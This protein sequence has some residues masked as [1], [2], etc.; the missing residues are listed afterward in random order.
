MRED[1]PVADP[2]LDVVERLFAAFDRRDADAMTAVMDP[3]VRFE[4]ASL[5]IVAREPYVGHAGI[6]RYL[7]DLADTWTEFRVRIGRL[8]TRGD[9]VLAHGRVYA[10]TTDPPFVADTEIAFLWRVR[11]GLIT[12]GR[13]LPDP[14]EGEV[15][16]ERAAAPAPP[17]TS[18]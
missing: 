14:A 10:R 9:V 16:L 11:D 7:D 8:Q 18:G 3:E 13:T 6:R 15:E 5:R 4:P 12:W 2:N 1:E 17:A